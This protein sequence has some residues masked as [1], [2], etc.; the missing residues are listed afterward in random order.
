MYVPS[1]LKTEDKN[2]MWVYRKNKRYRREWRDYDKCIKN[3]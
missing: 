3:N 2:I 1:G